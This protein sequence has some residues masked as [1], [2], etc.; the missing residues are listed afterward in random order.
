MRRVEEA[1]KEGRI[2]VN[3]RSVDK[4]K[5]KHQFRIGPLRFFRSPTTDKSKIEPLY[6][7]S[8]YM[9]L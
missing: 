6:M 4:K 5:L 8:K 1:N 9:Q 3:N 7:L 2:V